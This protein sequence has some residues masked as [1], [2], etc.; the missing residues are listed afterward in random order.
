[1]IINNKTS[2]TIT[3]NKDITTNNN[4]NVAT[5]TDIDTSTSIIENSITATTIQFDNIQFY[6]EQKRNSVLIIKFLRS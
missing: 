2:N 1:M 6:A 5:I 3:D 4:N